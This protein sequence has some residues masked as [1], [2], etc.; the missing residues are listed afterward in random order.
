MISS[1]TD[2]E[3][4]RLQIFETSGIP[5]MRYSTEGKDRRGPRKITQIESGES[6]LPELALIVMTW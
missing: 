3:R 6:V 1:H 2:N 4:D 5:L